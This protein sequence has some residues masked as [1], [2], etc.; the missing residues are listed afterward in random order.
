MTG[1]IAKDISVKFKIPAN[2]SAS[3]M[4]ISSCF[5]QGIIPYGAQLLMAAGLAQISPVS[6]MKYLY[7]PYLLGVGALTAIFIPRLLRVGKYKT[8]Y[9]TKNL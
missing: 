5:V 3:I 7:Y 1:P 4:D 8:A 2:K 6:I 9:I